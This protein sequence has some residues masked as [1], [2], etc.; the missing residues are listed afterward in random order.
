MISSEIVLVTSYCNEIEIQNILLSK[1]GI[2]DCHVHNQQTVI[3]YDPQKVH[4]D[5]I[6]ETV[7]NAGCRIIWFCVND[8]LNNLVTAAFERFPL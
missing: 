6:L 8:D 5:N 2:T 4:Y 1:K 7:A 3:S